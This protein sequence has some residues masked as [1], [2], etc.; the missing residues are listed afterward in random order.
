MFRE[1]LGVEVFDLVEGVLFAACQ[2]GGEDV[3]AVEGMG[4]CCHIGGR[5]G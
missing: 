5:D 2:L 3:E 1:I 4:W